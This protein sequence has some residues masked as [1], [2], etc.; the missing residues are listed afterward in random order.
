MLE[1]TRCTRP[2]AQPSRRRSRDRTM[3]DWSRLVALPSVVFVADRCRTPSSRSRARAR[4]DTGRHLTGWGD[5]G[6]PDLTAD[7]DLIGA[8]LA[9]VRVRRVRWLGEGQ[10]AADARAYCCRRR[11]HRHV[12][13]PSRRCGACAPAA[14]SAP[15]VRQL[16]T[17][18]VRQLTARRRTRQDRPPQGPTSHHE[19]TFGR[20]VIE[21]LTHRPN[22]RRGR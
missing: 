17:R 11:H 10:L 6:C 19:P 1:T 3:P 12:H 22:V 7:A 14:R 21:R 13:G 18:R 9:E 4:A 5:R 8:G 16:P 2:R 15:P 20:H